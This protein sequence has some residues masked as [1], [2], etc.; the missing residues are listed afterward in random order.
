MT[1]Q[2]TLLLAFFVAFGLLARLYPCN[3]GQPNF[4]SRETPTDLVYVLSLLLVSGVVLEAVTW[5]VLRLLYGAEAQPVRQALQEGR[6]ALAGLPLWAQALLILVISDVL[7]YWLHRAF[8]GRT[9]W[10]FHAIHHSSVNVD[11]ITTFRVHPVNYVLYSTSVNALVGLLGFSPVAIGVLAPINGAHAALVH[12]NLDWDFGPFRHVLA[13]PVFHR[14]HHVNDPE[15]R[16]KNFAPT[17]P[18]LDV[19]FG[20]FYM[21]KGERP[22]VYGADD[23]PS[24]G[25]VDQLIY[26]FKTL[27]G[28]RG[29]GEGAAPQSGG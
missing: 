12:A 28:R 2:I 27:W 15:V 17:F 3:R 5:G 4:V 20:T 7:Q 26:P 19:V 21:P 10:P 13:S 14:W 6:G 9:L 29:A 1:L 8:H 23:A 24:V 18:I 22:K 25:Y 16:D 11:W